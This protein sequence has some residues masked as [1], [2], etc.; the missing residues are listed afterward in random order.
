MAAVFV[1]IFPKK[2]IVFY[3][4][5]FLFFHFLVVSSV[6]E[7]KG[8]DLRGKGRKSGGKGGRHSMVRPLA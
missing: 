7:I 6:R 5:V 8:R 4:V 2:T 3:F 1:H